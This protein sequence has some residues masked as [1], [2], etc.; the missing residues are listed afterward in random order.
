MTTSK[1]AL[2]SA[3]DRRT[4]LLDSIV[5]TLL[6]NGVSD[7]SLRPLAEAVGTSA[8]LLIYHFDTKENLLA[9][10]LAEVRARVERSLRASPD[11]AAPGASND[12]LV[13]FWSWATDEANQNYFRLLFEV[14][15]LCMFDQLRFSEETRL[16]GVS[17]WLKLIGRASGEALAVDGPSPARAT[18]IMATISGL[19]QDFLSTGDL[20]RT[21]AAFLAFTSMVSTE[22]AR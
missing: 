7:L 5:D 16:D 2:E 9:C 19:L 12:A 10:A 13:R 18:L 1:S 20:E 21:T 11:H 6:K 22:P 8:R 3:S 4:A 15:G 17:V 14:D